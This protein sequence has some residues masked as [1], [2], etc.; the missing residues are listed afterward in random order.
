MKRLVIDVMLCILLA[1]A[2]VH[3]DS[4]EIPKYFGLA[5]PYPEHIP[6]LILPDTVITEIGRQRYEINFII[7]SAGT[8]SDMQWLSDSVF[9]P[10]LVAEQVKAMRFRFLPGRSLLTNHI[11]PILIETSGLLGR[12]DT[13]T[14]KFPISPEIRT[15]SVLLRKYFE[16]NEIEP[17]R[18]TDL[19]PVT[20]VFDIYDT[21]TR[22]WTVTMLVSIDEAG[23]LQDIVYPI[24][25]Q[26]N[27]AHQVHMA[28]MHA[29]FYPASIRG[30]PFAA[31]FLLTFRIFNNIDYP[32]SPFQ[33]QD[34]TIP[35][36]VT[37]RYFMTHYYNENDIWIFPLPHK[38]ARGY[39]R[40]AKFAEFSPGFANAT[41][42]IDETG[43]VERFVIMRCSS[44]LRQAAYEA[45]RL[46]SWYPAVDHS[47][48]PIAFTGRIRLEF[49][50][51]PRV[52]YIPEWFTP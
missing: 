32:F 26:R 28:V 48:E 12:E 35:P 41:I 51:S 43:N 6:A 22:C 33:T 29:S 4:K 16:A 27:M 11:I 1:A 13:L 45:G 50:G 44:G 52:V 34:T 5:V 7:D 10:S 2:A 38:H 23:Q 47:G 37:T 20:Y 18:V 21:T 36:R 19:P 25:R 39:I 46:I 30:K 15:D 40:G 9:D 49:S 17:P 8:V 24:P 14:M 3:A 42:A 31:D